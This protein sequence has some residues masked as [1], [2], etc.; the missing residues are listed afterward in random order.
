MT[1]TRESSSAPCD[2]AIV[3]GGVHGLAAAWQIARRGARV[4]LLERFGFGH[5]R[6][7]SHGPTRILRDSYPDP[8]YVA[9][10]R[11]ARA[12]DW[13]E[14]EA[15][16]GEELLTPWPCCLFGPPDGL[17]G[18]YAAGIRAA[19]AA[20]ET[21]APAAARERFPALRF[22]DDALVLAERDAA[23]IHAERT[24]RALARLAHAAGAELVEGCRVQ[25]IDS[26]AGR[27]PL[28][29]STD[30]GSW[31]ARRV[32]VCAG[33]WSARLVPSVA[34]RLCVIRQ[35]VAYL[36]LAANE[37]ALDPP[38]SPLW[39]RLGRELNDIHYGLPTPDSDVVKIARHVTQPDPRRGSAD[40]PEHPPSA[41]PES[42]LVELEA[43]VERVFQGQLVERVAADSCL[44][45]S[46][47]SEDF[48]LGA[49]PG[50]DGRPDARQLVATGF[51]GHGFKFAPLI[52]RVLADLALEGRTHSPSARALAAAWRP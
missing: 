26:A 8:R 25:S 6:G 5:E 17:I 24:L 11:E 15:A 21:L 14:L 51:S 3:G 50:A 12:R 38:G 29:V 20:T 47:V 43:E 44:Y 42:E 30:S 48:V 41:P 40:D 34:D 45:T 16:A 37:Q 13:P 28:E 18:K 19:G 22:A 32:A 49:T 46:T 2:V 31:T 39:I 4:V 9:L 10:A 27:G 23:V 36:R 1:T 7:S 35:S 33:G 52:G